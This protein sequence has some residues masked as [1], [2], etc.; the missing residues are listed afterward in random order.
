MRKLLLAAT[1]L[2]LCVLISGAQAE[3]RWFL[4][5]AGQVKTI[6]APYGE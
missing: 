4:H 5:R 1:A 6:W 2:M 3:G